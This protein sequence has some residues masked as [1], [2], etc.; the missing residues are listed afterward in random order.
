GVPSDNFGVAVAAAGNIAAV[1]AN[2]DSGNR[3]R[4]YLFSLTTGAALGNFTA[5]DVASGDGFGSSLSMDG[6][7][8]LA[9][10][11]GDDTARGSAYLFSAEGGEIVKF[12]ASDGATGDLFGSAVA[13]NGRN[14]LVGAP[15]KTG[16]FGALQGSAYLFN[17]RSF[18]E[19][20]RL[21]PHNGFGGDAFGISVALQDNVA[22]VG[23]PGAPL[24]L[25]RGFLHVF[26]L[27]AEPDFTGVMPPIGMLE[28]HDGN[29]GDQFGS[30]AAIS[31]NRVGV[32][33]PIARPPTKLANHGEGA[34]Y[35]FDGFAGPANADL[36]LTTGDASP[37]IPGASLSKF[38]DACISPF[39]E[40]A[41]CASLGSVSRSQNKA[42]FAKMQ[43]DPFEVAQQSGTPAL[44]VLAVK[45]VSNP[46]FNNLG[47]LMFD[48]VFVPPG[49]AARLGVFTYEGMTSQPVLAIGD[50]PG[51][52]FGIQLS[53]FVQRVHSIQL[54]AKRWCQVFNAKRGVAGVG[55]GNDSGLMILDEFGTIQEAVVEGDLVPAAIM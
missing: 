48:G 49:G 1:G 36:L 40:I 23:A 12:T 45:K 31:G 2:G 37:D 19:E 43:P 30:S 21:A 32:G 5:S 10:S 17:T 47:Y 11:P 54:G 3:G 28:A 51:P 16:G 25:Q 14:A 50:T 9:G 34:A 53:K 6:G 35:L 42:I 15:F 13:L 24:G 46:N 41:A 55:A 38:G 4:V 52:L 44:G 20:F 7:L 18:F 26:D 39:S 8:L 29:D 27:N 22:L 33:A